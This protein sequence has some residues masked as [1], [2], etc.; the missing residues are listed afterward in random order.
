MLLYIKQLLQ[1]ILSPARG[2]EDVSAEVMRPDEVQLRGFY[3]WLAVVGLSEFAR[4]FYTDINVMGCLLAAIAIAGA[5]AIS[6]E[7]SKIFLELIIPMQIDPKINLDKLRLFNVFMIGLIGMYRVIANL[8]P[9]SLT[10]LSFLP[11]L[12]LMV[13]FKSTAFL[14]IPGD[15]ILSFLLLAA[16][17]VIGLPIGADALLSFLI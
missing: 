9:P 2:W 3:P 17:S 8:L 10:L 16:I 15:R 1:L 13:I 12:S 11:A 7:L 6:L 4:L 14:G 5:L